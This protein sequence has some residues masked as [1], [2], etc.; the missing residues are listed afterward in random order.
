VRGSGGRYGDSRSA[1]SGRVGLAAVRITA[2]RRPKTASWKAGC[3]ASAHRAEPRPVTSWRG[4]IRAPGQMRVKSVRRPG[5]AP[6]ALVVTWRQEALIAGAGDQP[7]RPPAVPAGGQHDG[8]DRIAPFPLRLTVGVRG[9]P[10]ALTGPRPGENGGARPLGG[11][12]CGR[13]CGGWRGRL[14]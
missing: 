11:R 9:D 4:R 12:D 8:Q 7:Q 6:L 1:M 13:D 3:P 2:A 10:A 14:R 5:V